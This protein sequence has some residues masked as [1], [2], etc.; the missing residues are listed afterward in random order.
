MDADDDRSLDPDWDP[1]HDDAYWER[2]YEA[3]CD[4]ADRQIKRREEEEE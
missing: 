4:K 3:E 2:R 1:L